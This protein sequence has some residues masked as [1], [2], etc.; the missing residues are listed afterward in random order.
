MNEQREGVFAKEGR[1]RNAKTNSTNAF[2]GA[3]RVGAG[4]RSHM[5]CWM[6]RPGGPGACPPHPAPGDWE[7]SLCF[8]KSAPPTPFLPHFGVGSPRP[9]SAKTAPNGAGLGF[10]L[11]QDEPER[12]PNSPEMR[13]CFSAAFW[14]PPRNRKPKENP[15]VAHGPA[16]SALGGFPFASL[17][18]PFSFFFLSFSLF[19]SFFLF[20]PFFPFFNYYRFSFF[21]FSFPFSFF[22][23]HYFPFSSF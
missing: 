5:N 1:K 9:G 6:Y 13:L 17:F 11:C 12:T 23:Y 18:F 15:P 16:A 20:F 2:Q 10:W 19:F 4:E 7:F 22:N 21:L 14:G 8:R 3:G